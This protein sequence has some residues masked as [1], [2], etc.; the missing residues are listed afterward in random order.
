VINP[1]AVAGGLLSC[2]TDR[3]RA[4]PGP[5]A[6]GVLLRGSHARGAATAYS[7]LDLDLLVDG[8]PYQANPAFLQE[9][10]HRLVHV[11]VA[12]RDVESWFARLRSPAPWSFGLPVDAPARLLW[13]ADGWR[14]RLDLCRVRQPGS[15]PRLEDLVAG[16]G[17]LCAAYA[18]AD[19]AVARLAA[20]DLARACL[21]VLRL[22]NPPV[23]V[24][25]RREAVEAVLHL[26]VVPPGYD[27]DMRLCLGLLAG[28]LTEVYAA[29][30]RLAAGVVALVRPYADV[31]AA[32]CGRDLAGALIDGRL[33][34]YL[35]QLAATG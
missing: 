11:S 14:D 16:V 2:W 9:N 18:A 7:D 32:S 24:A 25:S 33:D 31:L 27:A 1:P 35:T 34:R 28:T 21:S 6:V 29:G 19:D 5:P 4:L 13:A 20:G 30:R 10:G 26:A 12:V 22:A 8:P 23:T 17:K 3:L 15:E